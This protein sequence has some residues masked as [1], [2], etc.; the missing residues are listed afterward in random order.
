MCMEAGNS[1]WHNAGGWLC[2]TMVEK[3]E[4]WNI[5]TGNVCG[6]KKRQQET[7]KGPGSSFLLTCCPVNNAVL[8][9]TYINASKNSA[10]MV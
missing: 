2:H 4:N 10:S 7:E 1:K 3:L 5:Q 9:K 6:E 8:E